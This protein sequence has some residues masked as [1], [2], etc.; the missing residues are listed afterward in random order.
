VTVRDLAWGRRTGGTLG[1]REEL[2][3]VLAAARAVIAERLRRH[4]AERL[5]L[6]PA[7]APP[8][9][10][11]ARAA[12]AAAREAGTDV[13]VAHCL[14]TWLWADLLARADRLSP[15]PE[16]LYAACLLHD[17]ALGAGFRG[18]RHG[19]F[20]V[21]GAVAAHALAAGHGFPHTTALADAVALH[22]D[23]AVPLSRG[24]E[25]HLLN[26]GAA[27]DLLGRGTSRFT[28]R[29][30]QQVVQAHPP[31]DLDGGLVALLREEARRR[32]RSRVAVLEHR[33][34][35]GERV[36]SLRRA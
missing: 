8:D 34:G 13:V 36:L 21:D 19:C 16:L 9:S 3:Y 7:T 4:P 33:F 23:V 20:A 31:G 35:F 22:L 25:A 1:R 14:R 18:A 24:V 11:F 17:V 5:D 26:A 2:G 30:R 15:D 6:E 32:P 27:A 29:T 12:E 28:V 10:T